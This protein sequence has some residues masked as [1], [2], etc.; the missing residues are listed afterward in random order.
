MS[1]RVM[2][3]SGFAIYIVEMACQVA[4]TVVF[5]E[6]LRPVNKSLSL[7]SATL[8]LLGIGIKTLSRLFFIAPLLI[9]GGA[10]YLSV[11]SVAQL[12]AL[13]LLL[14]KVNDQGAGMGLAFFGFAAVLKGLLLYRSTFLPRFLGVLTGLTGLCLLTYVYPPLGNQLFGLTAMVGLLA[15]IA[16]IGWLLVFGVDEERW[17]L[18][19]RAMLMRV[20]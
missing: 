9:L 11:F 17:K 8:G 7:L 10:H 6:L 13:A 1:Q 12:D 18:Q 5:Y 3:Q 19:A 20:E 2:F 16:S 15:S 14:L 4:A